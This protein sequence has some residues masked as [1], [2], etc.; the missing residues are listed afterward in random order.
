M[1]SFRHWDAEPLPDPMPDWLIE[2]LHDVSPKQ[3]KEV[4]A[5]LRKK[6]ARLSIEVDDAGSPLTI[7]VSHGQPFPVGG[8]PFYKVLGEAVDKTLGKDLPR[9][10]E[11]S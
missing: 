2:M 3:R 8:E 7:T 6:C 11:L 10:G 9:Q 4:E 1:G 5:H